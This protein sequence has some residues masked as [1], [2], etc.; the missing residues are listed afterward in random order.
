MFPNK[1]LQRMGKK[2]DLRV[3]CAQGI[4]FVDF[5]T[6]NLEHKTLNDL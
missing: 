4:I 3:T 2:V 5:L 1:F 6:K